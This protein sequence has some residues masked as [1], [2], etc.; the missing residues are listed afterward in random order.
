MEATMITLHFFLHIFWTKS[1]II[2]LTINATLAQLRGEAL[3]LIEKLKSLKGT[4]SL[5]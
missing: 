5:F 4:V 2:Y 3:N 1:S